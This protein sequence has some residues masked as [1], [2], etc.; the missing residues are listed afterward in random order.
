MEAVLDR[1]F[2]DLE[3][4]IVREMPQYF[5]KVSQV[6]KSF[7]ALVRKPRGKILGWKKEKLFDT[8]EYISENIYYNYAKDCHGF[9]YSSFPILN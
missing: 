4:S 3:L 2:N 6:K 1:M 9:R 8:V 7:Y 5:V